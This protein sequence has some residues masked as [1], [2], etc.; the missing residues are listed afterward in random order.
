MLA[1]AIELGATIRC[2]ARVT[3]C[4]CGDP[5]SS[6]HVTLHDGT[7]VA[8]DLIVGAD[9]ISSTM[10]EVMY[11]KKDPPVPTGD[12]AFRFLM[13]ADKVNHDPELSKLL[14][15]RNLWLG[16]DGHIVAYGLKGGRFLNMACMSHHDTL[17]ERMTG[18][19]TLEEVKALYHGWDHR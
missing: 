2:D 1:K 12:N 5:K 18:P 11:Q 14:H 16:P 3:D 19:A 9:G 17:G 6:A 7:S 15:E 10:R 13:E 8:G 4:S